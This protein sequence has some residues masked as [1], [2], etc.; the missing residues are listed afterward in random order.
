M[1]A[2]LEET[3]RYSFLVEWMDPTSQLLRPFQLSF[4]PADN[5]VEMYDVKNKK[6]FLKRTRVQGV[7]LAD[8]YMG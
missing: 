6:P 5:T 2:T 1:A 8:F 4:C 3:A 7:S